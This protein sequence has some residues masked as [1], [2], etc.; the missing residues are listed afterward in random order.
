M[1]D[2]DQAFDG[3]IGFKYLGRSLG[4]AKTRHQIW[5]VAN[6]RAKNLAAQRLPV[7]LIGERKHR[8]RM[9]V[10]DEFVRDERVQQR[11]DR[12]IRRRG[13]DQIGALQPHH[14]LIG[15]FFAPAK[16]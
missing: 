9:G 12:G 15:K 16:F 1:L 14:F 5:H 10:V 6:A 2:E 13:I 11:L 8:R 7:G 4:Q 3:W